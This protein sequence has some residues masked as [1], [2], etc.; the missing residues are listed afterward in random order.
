ML[1]EV[2]RP[3][4][5]R[6]TLAADRA[7]NTRDFFAELRTR[8]VTRMLPR[9]SAAGALPLTVARHGIRVSRE[10]PHRKTDRSGVWPGEVRGRAGQDPGPGAGK[11]TLRLHIDDR[12]LQYNQASHA[13]GGGVMP[14]S[15]TLI[16]EWRIVSLSRAGSTSTG[17]VPM[18]AIRLPAPDGRFAR[19]WQAGRRI[20]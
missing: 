17:M 2:E 12:R 13:A 11:R 18:K 10:Y 9:M 20:A 8:C 14:A 4:G 6:I 7:Y 3:D 19:R 5:S 15:A 16:R 1:D